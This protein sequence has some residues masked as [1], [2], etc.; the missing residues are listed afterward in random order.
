M[1]SFSV[2]HSIPT[3]GRLARPSSSSKSGLIDPS[4]VG[5]G[6]VTINNNI[7]TVSALIAAVQRRSDECLLFLYL[8]TLFAVLS[9]VILITMIVSYS[10][11]NKKSPSFDEVVR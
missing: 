5:G 2:Q 3:A 8:H 7:I 9:F 10:A 1:R 6:A 4:A 11:A